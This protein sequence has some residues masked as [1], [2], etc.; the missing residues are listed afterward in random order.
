MQINQ[1]TESSSITLSPQAS[2][3]EIYEVFEASGAVFLPIVEATGELTGVIYHQD[4]RKSNA[5]DFTL[6]SVLSNTY[7]F[8]YYHILE[9]LREFLKVERVQLPVVDTE[10][11]YVGICKLQDV[12]YHFNRTIGLTEGN[13]MLVIQT[14]FQNYSLVDIGRIV[15]S[16][17][18]K[19]L[20]FYLSS[21]PDSN[22]I[23]ITLVLNVTEIG[24]IIAT[25]NRFDYYVS[26]STASK[27]QDDLL[28]ERYDSLMHFL[29]I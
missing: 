22:Q 2:Y 12:Q 19:V 17:Q 8:D 7:L 20:N 18:A 5:D 25:F 6:D 10:G 28:K 14:T 9:T 4:F 24:D 21:H 16:N 27:E 15:E 13:S 11:F 1:I 29:D 23:E 26:Y 3:F